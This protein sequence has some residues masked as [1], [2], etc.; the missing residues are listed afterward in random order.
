MFVITHRSIVLSA[1]ALLTVLASAPAAREAP[2][3]SEGS[4]NQPA[5]LPDVPAG[6]SDDGELVLAEPDFRVLNPP[7]TQRLPLHGSSFQLTH[8]FNGDLREG[9]LSGNAGN[10]FG[11]D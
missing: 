8:R 2:S 3:S 10:L 1:T 4:R 5:S 7:S 9:S 11:L 6:D